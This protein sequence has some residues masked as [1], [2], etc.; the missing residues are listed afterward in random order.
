MSRFI[1]GID[2][3]GTKTLGVLYDING[4]EIKRSVSGFTNFNIDMQK[5]KSNMLEVLDDLTKNISSFDELFIQM[6]ISGYS[7]IKDK[8]AYEKEIGARYR[9]N[10]SLESDVL[11]A[12]YDVKKDDNVNVIIVI[13]GTGSVLMFS[14][15]HRLEQL[16]GFGHLLGDE[17]SAYHLSMSALKDVIKTYEQENRYDD[18]GKA[19]LNHLKIKDQFDI[20]DFVYGNDKTTVAGLA[21]F[22]SEL[23]LLGHEKAKLLLE[24]EARH[25]ARQTVQAYLKLTD[26]EKV[27]I[28]LRGGFLINAPY[29]K[30]TLVNELKMSIKDFEINESNESPVKGAYYLSL[31]KLSKEVNP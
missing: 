22:I 10:A 9:A 4:K 26:K 29:V 8:Q 1:I 7:K 19:I 2:G 6:G 31:L 16:G 21:K 13:G 30:E 24:D 11:I 15:Q 20:R 25:L 23:A 18:F 3:G 5:A 27:I 12:L 14:D 28:A 17:G